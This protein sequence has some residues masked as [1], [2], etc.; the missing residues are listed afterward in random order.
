MSTD[1]NIA[2]QIGS[3]TRSRAEKIQSPWCLWLSFFTYR[4][5]GSV[6]P[7]PGMPQRPRLRILPVIFSVHK[8]PPC[9]NTAHQIFEE[10]Q[11]VVMT[12]VGCLYPL[13][14][15]R[16][17]KEVA[18]IRCHHSA[19]HRQLDVFLLNTHKSWITVVATIRCLDPRQH[20]GRF[21]KLQIYSFV[22]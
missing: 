10:R 5:C 18:N 12:G 20:H 13:S 16:G 9:I 7:S 8:A 19:Q 6:L 15:I 1:A 2:K 22:C 21:R 14:N 17:Y 11:C 3:R 4:H